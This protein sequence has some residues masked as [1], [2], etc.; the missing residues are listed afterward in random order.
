MI[1]L[2]LIVVVWVIIS[3]CR[4]NDE[5]NHGK[6]GCMHNYDICSSRFSLIFYVYMDGALTFTRVCADSSHKI[7]IAQQIGP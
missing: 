6:F 5:S 3:K 2:I 4:N 7:I 1:L